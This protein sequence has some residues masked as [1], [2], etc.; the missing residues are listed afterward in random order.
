MGQV[1][2]SL[3]ALYETVEQGWTQASLLELP[4]VITAAPTQQE[5]AELLLDALH[6]YLLAAKGSGQPGPPPDALQGAVD[7][8]LSS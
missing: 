7:V 4:G 2:F 5:A 1:R 6:E 3:T 8:V